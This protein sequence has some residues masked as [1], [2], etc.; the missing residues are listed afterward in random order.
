MNR[1]LVPAAAV[2]LSVAAVGAG[3]AVWAA[4]GDGSAGCDQATLGRSIAE[5][6]GSAD[7]DGAVQF[8]PDATAGCAYDE[9]SAVMR[10]LTRE[11]HMMPDGMMMRSA[12]H[13]S[14]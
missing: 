8:M 10:E 5:G 14:R 11:W 2:A 9:M 6:I 4:G 13:V 7:A 3:V 12:G 1:W